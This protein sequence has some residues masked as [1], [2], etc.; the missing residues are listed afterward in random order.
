MTAEILRAERPRKRMRLST[1]ANFALQLAAESF[2]VNM[3]A[4]A[5]VTNRRELVRA[6]IERKLYLELVTIPNRI[7][8]AMG[9]EKPPAR[10]GRIS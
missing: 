6:A 10:F 2:T 5:C 4:H 7:A 9:E 1:R 8:T 3:L